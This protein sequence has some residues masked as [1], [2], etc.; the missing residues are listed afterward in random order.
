MS[1]DLPAGASPVNLKWGRENP[2]SPSNNTAS[3]RLPMATLFYFSGFRSWSI[4]LAD[5]ACLIDFG[6]R[7]L[8]D[9]IKFQRGFCA[10]S[11]FR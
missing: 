6:G 8:R 2:P 4:R 10:A 7:C 3:T 9:Y 1:P 11:S 5:R